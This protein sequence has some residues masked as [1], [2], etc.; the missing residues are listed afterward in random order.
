MTTTMVLATVMIVIAANVPCSV[1]SVNS[2]SQD[3]NFTVEE[4]RLREVTQHAH[5]HTADV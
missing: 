4:T 1:L 5:G 3:P 2:L